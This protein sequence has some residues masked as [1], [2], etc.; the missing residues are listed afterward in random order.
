[1]F[2]EM[3]RV[4]FYFLGCFSFHMGSSFPSVLSAIVRGL[5][6]LI[7]GGYPLILV[8]LWVLMPRCTAKQL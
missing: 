2:I 1:M 7:L 5:L 4:I 8:L 3:E 6:A